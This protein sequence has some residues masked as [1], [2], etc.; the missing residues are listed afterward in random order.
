MPR[1]LS[2]I[3]TR[4]LK[5]ITAMLRSP[6]MNRIHIVGTVVITGTDK[7]KI[8]MTET[9]AATCVAIALLFGNTRAAVE[10]DP[11]G[12]ATA[13]TPMVRE[14]VPLMSESM[15]LTLGTSVDAL[16]RRDRMARRRP[17]AVAGQSTDTSPGNDRG[18]LQ[19]HFDLAIR[20]SVPK[21]A[22]T[23][24]LLDRRLE[25]PLQADVFG[26]FA[27]PN[28]PLD[29]KSSFR[30]NTLDLGF[31]R[32]VTDRWAWTWYFGFG[33]WADRHHQR[34]LTA[35]LRVNF[36]YG[37][38]YS[39]IQA[40]FYPWGMPTSPATPSWP[41]R[42]SASRPFLITGVETAYVSGGGEGRYKLL[43]IKLYED[44][45]RVRDWTFAAMLGAGLQVPID[46]R[47]SIRV[48]G[49]YSFHVY[50]PDEYNSWRLTTGLRYAF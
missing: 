15:L 41:E 13:R 29:R 25:I 17:P 47:W 10:G 18:I 3:V 5:P 24:R 30:M 49:D 4:A 9:L 44:S 34:Y 12:T 46:T 35:D 33:V 27:H 23:K 19:R 42:L 14:W 40:E 48:A 7:G 2:V 43:G 36:D 26:V 1:L 31:G 37:F 32:R 16:S 6:R 20:T 21:L 11:A 50:R 8:S 22:E 45:E 38:Y 28:T 39:G